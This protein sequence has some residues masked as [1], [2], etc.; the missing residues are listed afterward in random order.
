MI[1]TGVQPAGSIAE[2]H[3]KIAQRHPA[4]LK[5]GRFPALASLL[6]IPDSHF[7]LPSVFDRK[8]QSARY[9][10]AR[11]SQYTTTM[12]SYV[13]SKL[14]ASACLLS[15]LASVVVS[16]ISRETIRIILWTVHRADTITCIGR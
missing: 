2:A 1:T 16:K 7:R 11:I 9:Y 15:L 3:S 13:T 12:R 8:L 4:D 14:P 6:C 5:S 10:R